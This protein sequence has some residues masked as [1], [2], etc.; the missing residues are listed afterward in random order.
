MQ[1]IWRSTV[2]AGEP[3]MLLSFPVNMSEF[4]PNTFSAS[5]YVGLL[6]NLK[7]CYWIVDSL[8]MDIQ[9]LYELYARS[10]Q[11]DVI[12]RCETEGAPVRSEGCARIKLAAS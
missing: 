9:V 7:E 10:N 2:V 11:V 1:Y 8:S 6:A 3:D 5:Q 4:V 12:A